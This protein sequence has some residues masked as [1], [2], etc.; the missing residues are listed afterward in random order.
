M[1]LTPV[2][3]RLPIIFKG[4]IREFVNANGELT[5]IRRST[6]SKSIYI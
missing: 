6:V 2:Y 3:L 5:L 4:E 1:M